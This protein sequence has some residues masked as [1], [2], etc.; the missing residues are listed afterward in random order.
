[1]KK[2]IILFSTL[3]SIAT[4]FAQAAQIDELDRVAQ[5]GGIIIKIDG[6]KR[7]F[8]EV[9]K[10]ATPD[11]IEN[12]INNSQKIPNNKIVFNDILD[13]LDQDGSQEAWYYYGYN[14]YAGWG[15]GY[16]YYGYRS[17]FFY[18]YGYRYPYYNTYWYR[19][20]NYYY[21]RW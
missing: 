19:G 1:M 7:E 10:N 6:Q 12:I 15:Y 8:F 13:E 2:L 21:Y 16:P 9:S 5:S 17:N 4:C 20:C 11:N 3:F 14:W 18:Y